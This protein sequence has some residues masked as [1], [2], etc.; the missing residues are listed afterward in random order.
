MASNAA[1]AGLALISSWRR[2]VRWIGIAILALVLLIPLKMVESVVRERHQNLSAGGGGH[3]RELE[4]RKVLAG[5]FLVV[6]YVEKA[7]RR[8]EVVTPTVRRRSSS[9]GRAANGER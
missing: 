6:P 3:R 2:P 5:P 7:E 9:A 1:E 4:R 8:D